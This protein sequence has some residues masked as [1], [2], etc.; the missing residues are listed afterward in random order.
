MSAAVL[1]NVT[2]ISN[3]C[4]MYATSMTTLLAFVDRLEGSCAKVCLIDPT[5]LTPSYISN[6]IKSV[7]ISVSLSKI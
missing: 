7:T 4:A 6:C 3:G 5:S 1:P 2:C